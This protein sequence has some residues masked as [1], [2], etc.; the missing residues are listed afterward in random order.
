MS[1]DEINVFLGAFLFSGYGKYPNKRMLWSGSPDVPVIVQTRIR[2]NR[3]EDIL[4]N[5]HINDNN[6]LDNT[7]RL[8]KLRPLITHLNKC[9]KPHG[10]CEENIS[11]DE[12]MIPYYGK[13]YAKQY[14]GGKSIRFGFKNWACCRSSGYLLSFD[15]Y[16]GKGNNKNRAFGI[17]GDTV[18]SLIRQANIPPHKGFK[19]FFDNYF[20]SS[21]LLKHLS[22]A[23]CCATDTIQ[24]SELQNALL[25]MSKVRIRNHRDTKKKDEMRS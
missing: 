10:G 12:S 13:H 11:I 17:L 25:P 1:L 6:N 20:S 5:F 4:I 19:I 18:I 21:D 24:D 8:L 22:E 2:L 16:T 23:G 14:I 7:D 15:I 3:F 9:Y